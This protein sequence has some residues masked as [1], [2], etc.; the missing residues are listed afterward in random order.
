MYKKESDTSYVG[1]VRDGAKWLLENIDIKLVDLIPSHLIFLESQGLKL[2]DVP[3]GAYT[4]HICLKDCLV[5]KDH[6]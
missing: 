2:Q 6:L 3:A 1:F 5:Q 4:V